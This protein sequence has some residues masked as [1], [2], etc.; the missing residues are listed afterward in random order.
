M[1]THELVD[2]FLGGTK[3]DSDFSLCATTAVEFTD[4]LN[5]LNIVLFRFATGWI[6]TLPRFPHTHTV[7][8]MPEQS[9]RTFTVPPA[10][11]RATSRAAHDARSP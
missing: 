11:P 5:E 7:S 4:L 9:E 1:A 6:S 8:E 10:S 2:D 3:N